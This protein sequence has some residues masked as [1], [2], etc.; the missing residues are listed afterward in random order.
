MP[1]GGRAELSSSGEQTG[2]C[3][4]RLLE[5][6]DCSEIDVEIL[7]S[8][9][10]HPA[11][12]SN[13]ALDFHQRRTDGFRFGAAQRALF[14][15]SYCLTFH[16]LADEFHKRQHQLDDRSLDVVGIRIP[17]NGCAR[18]APDGLPDPPVLRIDTDV[19]GSLRP[20]RSV[21][22][23]LQ[24]VDPFALHGF[25]NGRGPRLRRRVRE[26]LRLDPFG[27]TRSM[28]HSRLDSLR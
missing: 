7:R 12:I 17:T 16:Q 18:L 26:P 22:A 1:P 15:S 20:M 5:E 4:V 25:R 13:R 10:E 6:L 24:P 14:H 9:V 27:R 2:C 11:D 8:E 28:A 21:H 23:F 19:A 3:R